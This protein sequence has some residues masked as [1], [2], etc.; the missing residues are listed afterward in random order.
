MWQQRSTVVQLFSAECG[1]FRYRSH[2]GI[3]ERYPR[4]WIERGRNR[5]FFSKL[6]FLKH[7]PWPFGK[8]NHGNNPHS[9]HYQS[10]YRPAETFGQKDA[11]SS[12]LTISRISSNNPLCFFLFT[13][14]ILRDCHLMLEPIGVLSAHFFVERA[15]TFCTI[16]TSSCL[17]CQD[18]LKLKT[19][20]KIVN[21]WN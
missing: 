12:Q 5:T 4:C 1:L 8:F 16:S 20:L 21:N 6:L 2:T 3:S 7:L 10:Q 15:F 9:S 14:M 11:L 13:W 18:M 19:E 17:K